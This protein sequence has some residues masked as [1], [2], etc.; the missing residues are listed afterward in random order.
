MIA[1]RLKSFIQGRL[2]SSSPFKT[3][4]FWE[5]A[6]RIGLSQTGWSL[7]PPVKWAVVGKDNWTTYLAHLLSDLRTSPSLKRSQP[8]QAGHRRC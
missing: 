2:F 5:K 4:S 6:T 7:T 8:P 1:R 3:G